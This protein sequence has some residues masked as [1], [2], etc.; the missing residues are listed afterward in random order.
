MVDASADDKD[1]KKVQTFELFK[2]DEF[3]E[4]EFE[5][6]EQPVK[7]GFARPVIIHRAILGSVERFMAILIEHT[8]GKWPFFISPRQAIIVPISEKFNDYC[9]GVY[10]YLHRQ[11]Y[12]VELDLSNNTLNKKI[13]MNQK[14]QWNFILVAGEKEA[15]AGT[16]DVRTRENKRIGTKRIDQ[17]HEYFLALLPRHSNA[18]IKF[19]EKQW[20]LDDY[21]SG[22]E[23]AAGHIHDEQHYFVN[24]EEL[25]LYVDTA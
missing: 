24:P 8:A 6:K 19:Y 23:A 1:E 22:A 5:W 16:V 14:A 20:N 21:V 7:K 13:L 4:D 25:N 18:H 10:L 9:Q 2:P 12:Q 15:A 3:D 11:G 17:L